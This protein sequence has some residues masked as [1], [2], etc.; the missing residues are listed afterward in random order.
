MQS[1]LV[2]AIVSN[3]KDIRVKAECGPY[4]HLSCTFCFF[5]VPAYSL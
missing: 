1:V 3:W 2:K 4:L 5:F